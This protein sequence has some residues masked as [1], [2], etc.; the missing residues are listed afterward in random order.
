MDV[1]E[2]EWKRKRMK[3]VDL[4]FDFFVVAIPQELAYNVNRYR[5][6]NR[7]VLFG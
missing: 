4:L 2:G 6:D 1:L 7:T 5:E 3:K